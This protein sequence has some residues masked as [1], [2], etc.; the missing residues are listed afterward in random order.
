MLLVTTTSPKITLHCMTF[1]NRKLTKYEG[2]FVNLD[3]NFVFYV[4]F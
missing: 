3:I 1:L 2:V 4:E